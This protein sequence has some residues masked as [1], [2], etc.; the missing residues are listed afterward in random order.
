MSIV[1]RIR[2]TVDFTLDVEADGPGV[3]E[4]LHNVSWCQAVAR[5]LEDH[6]QKRVLAVEPGQR[7]LMCVAPRKEK[8]R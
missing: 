3:P 2:V 6:V 8:R 1:N 7:K 4:F 5:G